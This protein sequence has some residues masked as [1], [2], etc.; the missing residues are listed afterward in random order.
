MIGAQH[1]PEEGGK[2]VQCSVSDPESACHAV[3]PSGTLSCNALS[4]VALIAADRLDDYH[5]LERERWQRSAQGAPGRRPSARHPG[6][7][8]DAA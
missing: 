6:I 5:R 7:V 1:L 3:F 2:A 4:H 8:A